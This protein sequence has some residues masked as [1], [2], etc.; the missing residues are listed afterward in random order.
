MALHAMNDKS[1]RELF[2]LLFD[3]TRIQI[4]FIVVAKNG[5]RTGQAEAAYILT[6]FLVQSKDVVCGK[7]AQMAGTVCAMQRCR[8]AMNVYVRKRVLRGFARILLSSS[9]FL[10]LFTKTVLLELHH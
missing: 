3:G 2:A 1:D 9:F 5:F 8:L 4:D 10:F 6:M 7:W